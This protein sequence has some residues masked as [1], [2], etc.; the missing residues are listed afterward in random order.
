MSIEPQP[1]KSN[2]SCCCQ[3]LAHS[4]SNMESLVQCTDSLIITSNLFAFCRSNYQTLEQFIMES[5]SKFNQTEFN[6][7]IAR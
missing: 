6:R 4:Y 3:G 7:R 1:F 5:P 2:T